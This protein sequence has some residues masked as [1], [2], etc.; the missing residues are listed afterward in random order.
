MFVFT[1]RIVLIVE[2]NGRVEVGGEMVAML[3]TGAIALERNSADV[4][5]E[6]S[7]AEHLH[8]Y[9]ATDRSF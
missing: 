3:D 7:D 1:F 9:T 6:Q 5:L 2:S 8:C 4:V